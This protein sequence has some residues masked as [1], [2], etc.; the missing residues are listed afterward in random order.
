MAIGFSLK[1]TRYNAGKG[2]QLVASV[3]KPR[4]KPGFRIPSKKKA[5]A[6][7]TL[8]SANSES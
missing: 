5:S 3:T 2:K 8:I 4:G 1:N 6:A 7:S